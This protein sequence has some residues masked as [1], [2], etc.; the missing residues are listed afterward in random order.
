MEQNCSSS[1]RKAHSICDL[2]R[3]AREEEISIFNTR[4]VLEFA[5]SNN[6]SD[7]ETKQAQAKAQAQAVQQQV[8]DIGGSLLQH[9]EGICNKKRAFNQI[10]AKGSKVEKGCECGNLLHD[11][12]PNTNNSFL[13]SSVYY[14]GPDLLYDTSTSTDRQNLIGRKTE[15]SDDDITSSSNQTIA[16]RG[17]W[18]QGSLYY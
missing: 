17:N 16:S 2:F 13:G 6:E 7:K 12:N 11:T 3:E 8:K 10:R 5:S 1:A 18:W 14:G 9:R 4:G 15:K